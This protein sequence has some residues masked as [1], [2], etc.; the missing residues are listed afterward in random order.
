MDTVHS[1]SMSRP[2]TA[3]PV[4]P[5]IVCAGW[6]APPVTSSMPLVIVSYSPGVDDVVPGRA[7][8]V[9]RRLDV[10]HRRDRLRAEIVSADDAEVLVERDLACEVDELRACRDRDVA[11]AGRRMHPPRV[12]ELA[13]HRSLLSVL[14]VWSADAT[15]GDEP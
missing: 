2:G 4:T 7:D 14:W 6:P 13:S 3:S 5:R 1:I 12:D 9:D 15:R 8:R 11:E 10:P